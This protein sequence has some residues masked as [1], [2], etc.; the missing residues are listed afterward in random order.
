MREIEKGQMEFPGNF[1]DNEKVGNVIE[2]NFMNRG[3]AN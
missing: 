2:L 1:H 3:R